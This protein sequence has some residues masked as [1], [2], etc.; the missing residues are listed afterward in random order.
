M[1]P[2]NDIKLKPASRT[3]AAFQ[4]IYQPR[5][6]PFLLDPPANPAA[7]GYIGAVGATDWTRGWTVPGTLP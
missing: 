6:G 1:E 2:A 7:Q 4:S 5:A 3:L